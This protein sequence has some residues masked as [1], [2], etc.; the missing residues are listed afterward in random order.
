M[1]VLRFSRS[2][3]AQTGC[4]F[5]RHEKM[6]RS[7]ERRGGVCG[8]SLVARSKQQESGDAKA[9]QKSES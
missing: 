4:L 5:A 1:W 7:N 3:R 9:E 6:M 2:A 8:V